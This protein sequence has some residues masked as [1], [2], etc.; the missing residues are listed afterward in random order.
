LP[1]IVPVIVYL[2]VYLIAKPLREEINWIK[3]GK[4]DKGT[5]WLMVATAAV[6][7]RC[8]H[9]LD[10]PCETGSQRSDGYGAD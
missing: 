7:E 2:A 10:Y 3:W 6:Y 5:A 1:F 9:S 4:I 8:A